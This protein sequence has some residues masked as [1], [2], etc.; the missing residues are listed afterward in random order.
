M[1]SPKESKAQAQSKKKTFTA[2]KLLRR[3]TNLI[4]VMLALLIMSILLLGTSFMFVSGRQ[5]VVDQK[6]YREAAQLAAQAF[7]D[8]KTANYDDIAVGEEEEEFT[9]GRDSYIRRV[10]IE[11]TKT[12]TTELPKPCKAVTVTIEWST[13][14]TPHEANLMTYIGP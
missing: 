5:L 11:L 2:G 12:P 9:I 10:H 7:E 1:H 6:Y 8:L 14:N 4:E 13:G 3:G